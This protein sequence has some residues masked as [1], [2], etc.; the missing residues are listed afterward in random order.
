MRNN[1][2]RIFNVAGSFDLRD[3]ER[4]QA[5]DADKS[6]GDAAALQTRLSDEVSTWNAP[7]PDPQPDPQPGPKPDRSGRRD[8]RGDNRDRRG[9]TGDRRGDTKVPKSPEGTKEPKSPESAGLADGAEPSGAATNNKA[10]K[11]KSLKRYLWPA[12]KTVVALAAVLALGWTPLSR[13]LSTTS[14]EATVNARLVTL[15]APIDGTVSVSSP[16]SGVGT[17]IDQGSQLLTIDNPRADRAQLDTLR[18]EIWALEAERS[19]LTTRRSQLQALQAQLE[20]QRDAF[21]TGRVAQL[22]ARTAE[23]KAEIAAATAKQQETSKALTRARSLKESGWQS[24]AALDEAER[25]HK[26]SV[27]MVEALRQKLVGIDVE[28]AAARRGLFVGDSYNDIPRTAQRLDEVKQQGIELDGEI[29]E[30][31]L[32]I[33]HLKSELAHEKAQFDLR[34]MATLT[35]P[36]HGRVWEMLT[37]HGEQVSRGQDLMRVLDCGGVLVTAAVS[38]A[39]YNELS[40]GQEATFRLRG[41]SDEREARVVGLN[42]LAAVPANLAI[43]KKALA[44]EPYHV[45]VAV[46][47]LASG[48]N[49]HVGRSGKVTFGNGSGLTTASVR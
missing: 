27:N 33:S 2:Q 25:G 16:M 35:A 11:H 44:R 39:V 38:E 10:T 37:S 14:A 36:V 47:T 20:E 26:V 29:S 23:L 45:T 28:L 6:Q 18:R 31:S 19:T 12:V 9:D 15:R 46:P 8:R 17:T 4:V 24:H 40:L 22:E 7:Q 43:E 42:G 13:F 30:N 1:P 41:E 48:S 49:C 34:S 5:D 32:R 3:K 21:Q